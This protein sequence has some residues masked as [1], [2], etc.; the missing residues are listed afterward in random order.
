MGHNILKNLKIGNKR[1][2]MEEALKY[3][4]NKKEC[5]K[6]FGLSSK[7]Y[8]KLIS[9]MLREIK[10]NKP[11]NLKPLPNLQ[12]RAQPN[13]TPMFPVSSYQRQSNNYAQANNFSQSILPNS[14][15]PINST[16]QLAAQYATPNMSSVTGIPQRQEPCL[17]PG[18][19]PG[20]GHGPN[21]RADWFE[22]SLSHTQSKQ[23]SQVQ[24]HIQQQKAQ[25]RP[26]VGM[27]NQN[28]LDRRFFNNQNGGYK[29]PPIIPHRFNN[30]NE[31]IDKNMNDNIAD[32]RIFSRT[33]DIAQNGI[34][35]IMVERQSVASRG[36]N[37]RA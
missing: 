28:L 10:K 25:P 7:E 9:S 14:Y 3:Y 17:D 18:P 31:S 26:R 37:R 36:S 16:S 30:S 22:K 33:F 19:C 20:Q 6:R 12:L 4:S 15:A 21:H 8:D 1:I 29:V 23:Q 13:T 32:N 27:T 34:P 11:P 24:S 2:P 35:D 5:K